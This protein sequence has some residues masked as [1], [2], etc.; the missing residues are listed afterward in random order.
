MAAGEAERSAPGSAL[1]F[2]LGAG[3]GSPGV[4]TPGD[5]RSYERLDVG[6][7]PRLEQPDPHTSPAA[8]SRRVGWARA[9]GRLVPARRA[10]SRPHPPSGWPSGLRRCV[11]VAVSPGGVGSNPTP[12]SLTF[13]ATRTPRDRVSRASF[14]NPS[15]AATRLAP[16]T[17]PRHTTLVPAR[18]PSSQHPPTTTGEGAAV[19]RDGLLAPSAWRRGG[20]RKEAAQPARPVPAPFGEQRTAPAPT[21]QRDLLAQPSR[22]P[23][24]RPPPC[25]FRP[26]TQAVALRSS[27]LLLRAGGHSLGTPG[28]RR[29]HARPPARP[30][31]RWLARRVQEVRERRGSAPELPL[32]VHPGLASPR[33]ASPLGGPGAPLPGPGSQGPGSS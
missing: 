27:R 4:G 17:L 32:G 14:Q 12:D 19:A 31:G 8:A 33:L 21:R 16:A 18:A 9:R 22:P 26:L 23:S 13:L 3:A 7:G 15:S 2:G 28:R 11:Q 10:A 6:R 25:A 1:R 24:L 30:P 5:F 20:C 29:A